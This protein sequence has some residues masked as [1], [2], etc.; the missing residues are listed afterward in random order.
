M[1]A[2]TYQV[3]AELVG[4]DETTAGRGEVH[5]KTAAVVMYNANMVNQILDNAV[6]IHGGSGYL[7]ETEVNRLF[8]AIKLGEIGAGT[9]EVRK[10]I[11]AGE[12]LGRS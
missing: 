11:I 5:A 9:T 2:F 10:L 7:W 12:I 8:R 4:I 1:K 3:L 6:Q